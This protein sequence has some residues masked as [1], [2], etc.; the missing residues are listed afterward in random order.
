MVGEAAVVGQEN[1]FDELDV[2]DEDVGLETVEDAEYLAVFL[3]HFHVL[4][5][6]V[7]KVA[8]RYFLD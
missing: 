4:V 3:D 1:V 2:G 7:L 5:H 8:L 6:H